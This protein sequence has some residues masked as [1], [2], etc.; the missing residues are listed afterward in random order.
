MRAVERILVVALLLALSWQSAHAA[1]TYTRPA[2]LAALD[3]HWTMVGDVRGKPVKYDME[4]FPTL[5]GTFTEMHMKD[6]RVP[7]EYEA[8]VFIGVDESG[9]VIA[10]WLDSFGAIYS[11][12]HGAGS[13]TGNVIV[14]TIP[15]PSGSFR[16]TLT[17]QPDQKIWLLDIEA[18]KSD[19]SWQHFAKYTIRRKSAAH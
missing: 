18:A 2:L 14:F 11:I 12:P 5:N 8:R 7:S 9:K 16:D 4:A 10:H 1:G 15:Y 13:I 6:V 3:G 17:Y 19:G